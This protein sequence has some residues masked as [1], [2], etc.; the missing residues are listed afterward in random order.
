MHQVAQGGAQVAIRPTEEH[1]E[2]FRE[3]LQQGLVPGAQRCE[4][5][6]EQLP[7]AGV[8]F[9]GRHQGGAAARAVQPQPR[10]EAL[11]RRHGRLLP[12]YMSFHATVLTILQT[13]RS[14]FSILLLC[15]ASL[16]QTGNAAEPA[17]MRITCG[18]QR[19]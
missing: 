15:M 12:T 4:Q 17:C 13:L 9:T 3:V 6:V 8:Q 1:A 5:R 10:L 7:V 18:T 14:A 11:H 2:R 19:L 16:L